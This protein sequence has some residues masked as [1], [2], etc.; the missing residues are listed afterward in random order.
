M[1][2]FPRPWA[3]EDGGGETGFTQWEMLE[4][5]TF[6]SDSKWKCFKFAVFS[7]LGIFGGVCWP[8]CPWFITPNKIPWRRPCK[9]SAGQ[10]WTHRA[11]VERKSL[12]YLLF[13]IPCASVDRGMDCVK[14]GRVWGVRFWIIWWFN[15]MRRVHSPV[16]SDPINAPVWSEVSL[17]ELK[18]KGTHLRRYGSYRSTL[19]FTGNVCGESQHQTNSIL[20]LTPP[21][22]SEHHRLQR[23]ATPAKAWRPPPAGLAGTYAIDQLHVVGMDELWYFHK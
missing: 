5:D 13:Y 7:I 23:H 16:S 6:T 2:Y 15:A 20:G 3:S 10:T 14:A 17:V 18:F 22:T 12:R 9:T 19:A 4:L 1:H 11:H 21:E 8:H